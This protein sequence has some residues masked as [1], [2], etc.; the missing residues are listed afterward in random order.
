MNEVAI[1][2]SGGLDS[3]IAVYYAK[4]QGLKPVPFYV[5]LGHPYRWKER[6][7]LERID[8]D[9]LLLDLSPLYEAIEHRLKNQI[10]PSRNL[11]FAVLGGMLAPRIWIA[12]LD[13][14]QLG[15]EHDK[16]PRFF[17]DTTTLLTWIN[18]FFTPSTV[19]ET[20]FANMSKAEVVGWALEHG[21]DR[22][23]L[24]QT[25][26]CY[27]PD[28]E[29]CGVCLTC[30]KRWAAFKLND[31]DEPGYTNDPWKS[32]YAQ[33]MRREIPKA[34]L[35]GDFSR[36]TPKRIRE[37]YKLMEKMGVPVSEEELATLEELELTE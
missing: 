28:H 15:K 9:P 25:S 36:F 18:E 32:E 30:Y 4:Q 14:E 16:S 23:M 13:G 35:A 3:T 10:I 29:K 22:E 27:S 7:A 1:P 17:R 6:A 8:L 11:L 24:F 31:V 2:V 33:E 20:P 5:D 37:H 21:I 26:S 34:L 19:V 12:A